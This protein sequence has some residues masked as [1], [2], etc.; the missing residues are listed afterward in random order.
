MMHFSGRKV[1]DIIH[2]VYGPTLKKNAITEYMML[3][4]YAISSIVLL[5][6]DGDSQHT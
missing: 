1:V 2:T 6:R 5:L 4:S 3:T